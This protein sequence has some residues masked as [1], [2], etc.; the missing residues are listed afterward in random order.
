MRVSASEL[1]DGEKRV[2]RVK[3]FALTTSAEACADAVNTLLALDLIGD[4][5]ATLEDAVLDVR[6]VV[7]DSAGAVAG[8]RSHRGDREC[9][10]VDND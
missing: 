3:S 2:G 9:F 1:N 7:E 8:H 4:D 5:L 6:G 10:A